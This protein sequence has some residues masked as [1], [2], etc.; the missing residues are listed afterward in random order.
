MTQAYAQMAGAL[1]FV[2]ILIFAAG[3]LMRK[4]QNKFGLMEVIS[5]HSF[6][7]KKGVAALKVGTEVLILGMT[8]NEMRLLRTFRNG[9]LE[10]PENRTFQNKLQTIMKAK[11]N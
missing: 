2:I 6:G 10:L 9:E 11:N 7:P 5:Y 1:I 8:Q 4:K 3:F